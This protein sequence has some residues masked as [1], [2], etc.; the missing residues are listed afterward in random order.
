MNRSNRRTALAF[1]LA[2]LAVALIGWGS[3]AYS[4][5]LNQLRTTLVLRS[6]ASD[7]AAAKSSTG[8]LPTSLESIEGRRLDSWGREWVYDTRDGEFVL[9]SL[10]RDGIVS[11]DFDPWERAAADR[12]SVCGD[13]DA[14]L[15]TSS[16]ALDDQKRP[17]FRAHQYCFH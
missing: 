1:A 3:Y 8:E 7:I 14:E 5:W 15:L 9:Y 4:E 16:M 2:L 12:V 13:F 17:Q 6:V 10:G 11:S